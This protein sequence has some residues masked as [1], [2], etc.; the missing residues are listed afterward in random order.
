MCSEMLMPLWQSLSFL[1]NRIFNG[2]NLAQRFDFRFELSD[3]A[4]AAHFH[5]ASFEARNPGNT[6]NKI[7]VIT[8][9]KLLRISPTKSLY[10]VKHAIISHTTNCR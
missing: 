8:N 3:T 9:S 2:E 5:S 1:T 7:H 6:D 10:I 4:L